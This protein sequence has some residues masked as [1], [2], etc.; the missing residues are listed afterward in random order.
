MTALRYGSA[1]HVGRVRSVNQDASLEA[2][3][4][5]AVADGMGGAAAGEVAS[6]LAVEALRTSIQPSAE[7]LVHAVKAAN[8]A[9][10]DA[11]AADPSKR[12]MGTTMCAIVLVP[13][14]AA[15]TGTGTDAAGGG[16]EPDGG[17]AGDTIVVANVGDSRVYLLHD[18]EL[19]QITEDHSLVE[20]LVRQ[21]RITHEEARTHPQRNIVTRVLGSEDDVD[22]DTFAIDPYVGDRFLLCSDGLFNEVDDGRIAGVLR[23]LQDP[24]DA[25]A[26][27]VRLANEGGG[28]DNITIVVVDVVDDDDRS[29]A[30]SAALAADPATAAAGAP[31]AP[32]RPDDPDEPGDRTDRTEPIPLAQGAAAP[33][34]APD[35]AAVAAPTRASRRQRRAGRGPRPRRFTW[36]VAVF[37]L[38]FFA[39]L[40]AAGAGVA[41]FA[42]STYYVGLDGDDVVIYRGRP[43][44]VLWIEPTL[45]E[46][47][48]LTLADVPQARQPDVEAGKQAAD[49]EAARLYVAR[50]ADQAQRTPGNR[51]TTTTVPPTPAAPTTAPVPGTTASSTP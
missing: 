17:Q 22:V 49:L 29:G 3:P 20:D 2:E 7:G 8:R 39:V 15:G 10:W 45:S 40:G 28:R 12:G 47:T 21:G 16:G 34:A 14:A 5:F 41:W 48:G 35:Q 19:E 51:T 43:G 18:G 25:A 30:A 33:N 38:A 1:T 11:A 42:R 26:E 13:A 36:R 23:R 27:L 9:V 6:Q 44:G 37:L 24:G 32:T 4:V 50:L 31:G 46:R